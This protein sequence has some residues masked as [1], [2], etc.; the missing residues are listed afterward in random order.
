MPENKKSTY[1]GNT[2]AQKRAYKKYNA[3][4]VEDIKLRVPKGKKAYYQE[5]AA[6]EGLSLNQFAISAMD[7]KIERRQDITRKTYSHV[8][9]SPQEE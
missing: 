5:A 4:K 7:E 9:S 8:I 2:E 3:E 6:A 1:R